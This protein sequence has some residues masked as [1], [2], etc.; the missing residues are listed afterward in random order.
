MKKKCAQSLLLI[1]KKTYSCDSLYLTVKIIKSKYRAN[2]M[3]DL[4]GL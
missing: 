2:L 3:A 1:F 4:M